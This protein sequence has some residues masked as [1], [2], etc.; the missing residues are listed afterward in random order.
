MVSLLP[1]PIRNRNIPH[2]QLHKQQQRTREMLNKALW[3]V[4]QPLTLK[5]NPGARSRY[6]NILSADAIFRCWKSQSAAWL[7]DCPE[8]S[9]Q[10]HV[11]QD[12][13]FLFE[14]PK[15][16]LADYDPPYKQH[17]RWDHNLHRTLSDVIT[18][19]AYAK[20]LSHHVHQ[21]FNVFRHLPSIVSDLTIPDLLHIMLTGML[22]HRQ[23]WNFPS[24][25]IHKGIGNNT[26]ICL[27]MSAYCDLSQKNK[28]YEEVSQ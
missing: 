27:F 4:L 19:A 26:A 3:Q 8:C 14:S 10:D 21:E 28:S 2:M 25:I 7:A 15:N 18:K 6:C 20:L 17:P 16:K 9:D 24:M 13:Y 5:L 12:V 22:D 1:I 11:E 23:K